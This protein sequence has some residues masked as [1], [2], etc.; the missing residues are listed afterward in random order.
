MYVRVSVIFAF[1]LD[2]QTVSDLPAR[3]P[4]PAPP[5]EG[6][7]PSPSDAIQGVRVGADFHRHAGV[8]LDRGLGGGGGETPPVPAIV[9]KMVVIVVHGD[10]FFNVRFLSFF[11][12]IFES[13]TLEVA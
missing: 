12:A 8:L 11:V 6:P 10:V 2:V 13:W 9:D 5:A 4:P 1:F 3:P 7:A